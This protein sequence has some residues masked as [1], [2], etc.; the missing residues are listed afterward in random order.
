MRELFIKDEY[1]K[2]FQLLKFADMVSSGGEA[3]IVI[4]EYSY[5][6]EPQFRCGVSHLSG[7]TEPLSIV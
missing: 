3:K 6:A 1:I 5:A 2:L 4:N 7:T